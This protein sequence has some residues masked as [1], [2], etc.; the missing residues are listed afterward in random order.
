MQPTSNAIWPPSGA[1]WCIR[2]LGRLEVVSLNNEVAK[3]RSRT[4]LA[5]LAYLALNRGKECSSE[6]LQ[7]IFWPE[8]DAD[9]QSQNLRRAVADLRDV[10]EANAEHGSVVGTKRHTVWIN[11]DSVY[12]DVDRFLHLTEPLNCENYDCVTEAVGLYS[13]PLLPHLHESWVLI[14]RMDLE[15]RFTRAVQ[16]LCKKKTDSGNF[17]DAIR[18]A[19]TAVALA[20][21]KEEMHVA[22]ITAYRL[23]GNEAGAIRQYEELERILNEAWGEAPSEQSRIALMND[24]PASGKLPETYVPTGGAMPLGSRY[25]V[26]RS[27]DSQLNDLVLRNDGVILLQGPRQVGKSSVLARTIDHARTHGTATLYTD[28]QSCGADDL[29]E[30]ESFYRLVAYQLAR[31]IAPE[32]DVA[33]LWNDALGCNSNLDSVVTALLRTA[34]KNVWWAID[35]ADLLFERSYTDDFFGLLRSWHNRRAFEP[36]GPWAQFMLILAYATEAHL[37]I[38]DLNQSPFNVGVRKHLEDFSVDETRRL[39]SRYEQV[40]ETDAWK[41]VYGLTNGHPYLCQCAF[42]F[43]ANGS[44]VQKLTECAHLQSGPFGS[45]LSR[46]LVTITQN[47]KILSEI[48]RVLKGKPFENPTTRLRL[49]SAGIVAAD[50]AAAA[51]FRTPVYENY[52][53]AQLA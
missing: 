17:D 13:G 34:N 4:A 14:D 25:Y 40:K 26:Q 5:L 37:F 8:K 45:H 47:E 29:I 16:F 20:P 12:S 51:N 32:I 39:Q 21:L 41:A 9:R 44:S 33:N 1:T 3:F 22:L 53:R 52:L 38:S 31:Q 18:I 28:V 15:E 10:L 50:D 19:R 7:E 30:A 27:I 2:L 49:Q 35:E 48:K 36:D 43:L 42:A 46:L 11:R 24:L 23:G 6:L